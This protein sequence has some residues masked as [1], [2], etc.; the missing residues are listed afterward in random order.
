MNL[1]GGMLRNFVEEKF[2]GLYLNLVRSQVRVGFDPQRMD[3]PES[4]V[5]FK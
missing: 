5:V 1:F 3:N 2:D 4:I